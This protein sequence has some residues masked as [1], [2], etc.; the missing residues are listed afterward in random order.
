MARV[1]AALPGSRPG[2]TELARVGRA[3][4]Q[5]GREACLA[6][7]WIANPEWLLLLDSSSLSELWSRVNPECLLEEIQYR[8]TVFVVSIHIGK[9]CSH[10]FPMG[11]Q[12]SIGYD[13][14]V[15]VLN[16]PVP[17]AKSSKVILVIR[18]ELAEKSRNIFNP[19]AA[20]R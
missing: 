17:L 12:V 11:R 4:R 14:C 13:A 7:R 1:I 20:K 16:L 15:G 10:A 2:H 9:C 6:C 8:V 3:L 5:V 19:L 18:T